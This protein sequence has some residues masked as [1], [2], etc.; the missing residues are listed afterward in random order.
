MPKNQEFML[1]EIFVRKF[2]VEDWGR[3][4]GRNLRWLLVVGFEVE[5]IGRYYVEDGG[6]VCFAEGDVET[7]A[8]QLLGL[9]WLASESVYHPTLRWA[10]SVAKL[11]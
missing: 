5:A 3:M 10:Q 8:Y 6:V 11:D 4:D 1:H 7:G 2:R 9:L